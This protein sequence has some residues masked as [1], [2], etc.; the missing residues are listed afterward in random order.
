[1]VGLITCCAIYVPI[2]RLMDIH[3]VVGLTER[4]FHRNINACRY[5]RN[6]NMFTA[7]AAASSADEVNVLALASLII[8]L[9]ARPNY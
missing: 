8:W 6:P 5:R 9:P 7:G 3:G 1:M 2:N 4:K